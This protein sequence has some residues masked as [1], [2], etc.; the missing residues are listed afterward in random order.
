M[1]RASRMF[2]IKPEIVE[3]IKNLSPDQINAIHRGMGPLS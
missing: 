3:E 2:K 1:L